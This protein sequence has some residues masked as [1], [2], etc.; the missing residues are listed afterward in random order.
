MKIIE[1][2]KANRDARAIGAA[3]RQVQF[4]GALREHVVEIIAI[5]EYRSAALQ[6]G[7]EDAAVFPPAEI[8]QNGDVKRGIR[9]GKVH[10][11]ALCSGLDFHAG[12]RGRAGHGFCNVIAIAGRNRVLLKT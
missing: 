9:L 10:S 3:E 2:A 4:G 6:P 5:Y 7:V 12:K 8:A 11:P 1:F